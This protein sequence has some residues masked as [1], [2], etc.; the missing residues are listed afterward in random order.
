MTDEQSIRS[1]ELRCAELERDLAAARAEAEE[2]RQQVEHLRQVQSS[3]GSV[4]AHELRT[5]LTSIKGIV[6]GLLR[7]DVRWDA[8]RRRHFLQA[9]DAEADRLAALLNDLLE[10]ARIESGTLELYREEV[11]LLEVADGLVAGLGSRAAEGQVRVVHRGGSTLA[12]VDRQRIRLVLQ[13]LVD[14]ALKY[15]REGTPVTVEIGAQST[16]LDGQAGLRVQVSDEG[17]GIRPEERDRIFEKLTRLR[18]VA[19]GAP[20]GSGLGLAICRGIVAAHGG[21]IWVENGPERGAI[22][23]LILPAG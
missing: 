20:R 22:F 13:H 16:G 6:S 1:L 5:P 3:L 10:L 17:P 8:E 15:S 2:G 9:V 14:N 18:T 19:G 12:Q 7:A 23:K 21:R 4:I 11:D